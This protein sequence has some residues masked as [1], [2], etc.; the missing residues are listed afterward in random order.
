MFLTIYLKSLDQKTPLHTSC[1]MQPEG[2]MHIAAVS[3]PFMKGISLISV[4]LDENQNGNFQVERNIILS[5]Q[6]R[7]R[8]LRYE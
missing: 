4:T 3:M 5:K 7:V 1:I 8:F 6:V 2:V